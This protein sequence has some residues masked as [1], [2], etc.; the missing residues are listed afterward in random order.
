MATNARDLKA[1]FDMEVTY[2]DSWLNDAEYSAS[3][4][5]PSIRVRD[6]VRQTGQVNSVG[7]SSNRNSSGSTP[8][9]ASKPYAQVGRDGVSNLTNTLLTTLV[10]ISIAWYRI[11]IGEDQRQELL[12]NGIFEDEEQLD[13]SLSNVEGQMNDLMNKHLL[14]TKLHSLFRRNVIEG[15]NVLNLYKK[16][17]GDFAIRLV[18]FR[19]MIVKRVNGE[20]RYL[21]LRDEVM[22]SDGKMREM[23]TCV[24]YMKDVVMKQ[25]IGGKR[26]S[27]VRSKGDR[28]S[29]YI[30]VTSSDPTVEDYAESY[31][32]ELIGDLT[33]VN[34]L[35]RSIDRAYS[36]YA[37]TILVNDSDRSGIDIYDLADLQAGEAIE[38]NVT[39]D[40]R[41]DG[42]GFVSAANTPSQTAVAAQWL[43]R[44]ED[45]LMKQFGGGVSNLFENMAQPRTAAE[46]AQV[47]SELDKFV[48]GL[49][50]HYHAVLLRPLAQ[51]YLDLVMQQA[52]HDPRQQALKPQIVAGTTQLSRL[53]ELSRFMQLLTTQLQLNPEFANDIKWRAVWDRMTKAMGIDTDGL[54]KTPEE[55][56]QELAA[57]QAAAQAEAEGQNPQN[58]TEQIKE[59]QE[60]TLNQQRIQQ[61]NQRNGAT[62]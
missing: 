23:Y 7:S 34:S 54:L 38:G 10:P 17:D 49:G 20:V 21:Y 13:K 45:K 31:V 50:Q 15:N 3:L 61:N 2:R 24:D 28:A 1:E 19:D 48:S 56:Q 25:E 55:K 39:P 12:E 26:K 59:A 33:L 8:F 43:E 14:R 30:V 22:G 4:T 57:A 37:K 32:H 40:G 27:P 53:Q 52:G 9:G 5:I 41:A 42:I 60:L 46:I 62:V 36:I 18:P 29:F 44:T 16:E 51:A 47:S 58:G 11:V 6:L 35:T